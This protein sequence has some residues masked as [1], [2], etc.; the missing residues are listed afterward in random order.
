MKIARIL[1]VV[2]VIALIAS[3]VWV[4]RIKYD[5]TLHAEHAAKLKRQIAQEIDAVAVLNAEWAF[6]ARLDRVQAFAVQHLDLKP[7]VREQNVR[8][9]SLPDRPAPVDEIGKKLE[10]LGLLGEDAS[11]AVD[12]E[13]S[14]PAV[15]KPAAP[16]KKTTIAVKPASQLKAPAPR[17]QPQPARPAV[18]PPPKSS[19]PLNLTDF[20]KKIGIVR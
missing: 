14:A 20:L 17:V 6:L 1:N 11:I 2:A 15:K 10:A 12:K 13:P 4:Y 9:A 3:A 5:A 16:A 18:A 19:G 7:L 8:L